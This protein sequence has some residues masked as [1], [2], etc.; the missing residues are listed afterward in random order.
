MGP[1]MLSASSKR[2]GQ[3]DIQALENPMFLQ[4]SGH[5]LKSTWI[6]PNNQDPF[7]NEPEQI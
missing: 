6:I 4:A 7:V 1:V 5:H 3:P 2:W